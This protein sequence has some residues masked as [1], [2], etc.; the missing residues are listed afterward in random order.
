M[1]LAGFVST[2]RLVGGDLRPWHRLWTDYASVLSEAR[3]WEWGWGDALA[4]FR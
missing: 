3:I 1:K 2:S 4:R